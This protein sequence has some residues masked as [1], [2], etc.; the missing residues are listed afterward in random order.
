LV[1]SFYRKSFFQAHER[2]N[3]ETD[4]LKTLKQKHD[5][6]A[7]EIEEHV[8]VSKALENTIAETEKEFVYELKMII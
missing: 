5:E 4:K 3:E 7:K 1:I 2:T 8:E 6:V